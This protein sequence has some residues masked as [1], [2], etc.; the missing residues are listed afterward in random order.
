MIEKVGHIKNPLTVIAMFAG[1]A[2]VSGTVILPFLDK[3]VQA[4]FVWFLM[5]F[6]LVLVCSF[7]GTLLTK[8]H[9]LYAPSDFKD[10]SLFRDTFQPASIRLRAEK[11]AEEVNAEL[12][13]ATVALAE[14]AASDDSL[15]AVS[16]DVSDLES[17]PSLLVQVKKA[18]TGRGFGASRTRAYAQSIIADSVAIGELSAEY[19]VAFIR[20]VAPKEVPTISFDAVAQVGEKKLVVEVLYTGKSISASSV[21]SR[22]MHFQKYYINLSRKDRE[23]TNFILAV[24]SDRDNPA[25]RNVCNRLVEQEAG[26]YSF[27]VLTRFFVMP[28]EVSLP[29]INEIGDIEPWKIASSATDGEIEVIKKRLN[30]I[31]GIVLR[32]DVVQHEVG[33]TWEITPDPATDPTVMSKLRRAVD[34]SF[35][36]HG[37]DWKS[38]L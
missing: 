7:F 22:L 5:L 33:S 6:P 32:I 2:E 26:H 3:P 23:K 37:A 21:K 4:T 16:V 13:P 38:G 25:L 27:G 9:V 12:E 15:Q 19:G 28:P 14:I 20:D 10:E 30:E 34:A 17:G 24:V 18:S 31:S 8:H 11:L 29:Y 35:G 1:I 36:S